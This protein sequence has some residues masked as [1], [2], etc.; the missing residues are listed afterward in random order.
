MATDRNG[1]ESPWQ[2]L[3]GPNLGYVQE[4]YERYLADPDSIDPELKQLFDQ[5]G[6]PPSASGTAA[7]NIES[8]VDLEKIVAAV[9]F[10]DNIRAYGHLAAD[11]YPVNGHD[12][13][14]RMLEPSNYGLTE[15]DLRA[16]PARLVWKGAPADVRD[17][18]EA[19]RRLKEIYTQTIAYDFSHVHDAE[20]IRW[21]YEMAESGA[22]KPAMTAEK[23]KALLKELTDVEGFETFLHRT[24]VGQKRFSIEGVDVLVPMLNE[25]I[26][27]GVH[28]GAKNVIIGMA[29][30]GR[31]NVLAHVL[32]KPLELIIAEFA[33][34]PQKSHPASDAAAY[35]NEGW[36]G[37]VKYHLGGKY[38]IKE[39][40]AVVA[41]LTLANNPSHLEVVDPVVEG[42]TRAAQDDRS[43]RGYPEQDQNKAFAI[44]VHGDA[45]FPGEGVVAETLNLSR[46]RGYQTGGTIHIIANNLIG[47][48]TE[49]DDGRST[50]Y[51]SDLAKGFEIPV[52][53]VNADDPEAC[54]AAMHF[55]YEYRKRF[56]KDFL[57]DLIG[58][59]RLGHNEMDDPAVTQP[60]LYE[61]ISNHKRV[62]V[63]YAEKL[64]SEGVVTAEE[65][66]RL[67]KEVQNKLQ[68]I[69][70]EIRA[71]N[72]GKIEEKDLP[73]AVRGKWPDVDTS[74]P[75][76]NLKAIN[77]DLLKW[78]DGFHVYRKLEKIL[79]RRANAL[80]EGGKVDWGHAEALA[81]ATILQ[82]G[83]PI[84][85]TGQDAER[86][87]FAHR[88]LVL[89]DEA[90]G[91][92][93]SPLHGL[94]Q[95]NASFAIHNSPLTETAVLG[96]EYG[97][98]VF[99]PE[100][101]VLWEAQ[102][103]D[104]ANVAQPIFDQFISAGR[105]KW[106]QKSG[107]VMLLPH[108]YE[109][110]GAEHSSARLERYL[111]LAAENNW[112]VANLTSSAQYF[113]ILRR[114]AAMLGTDRVRP[115]VLMTPKSLLRHQ[116]VAS[117]AEAFTN[118]RFHLVLE[119]PGLGTKPESVERLV[120]ASGK[121]AIDLAAA[122]EA[123]PENEALN[124]IHIVRV[125]QLYPFPEEEIRAVLGRFP[126]LKEI[127]WVQEEPK[128]MGAWT[129]M[130]PRLRA[131]APEGVPVRYIGR[132]DRSSPAVGEPDVH[133][134]EQERIIKEALRSMSRV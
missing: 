94:P 10:A 32:K 133:K 48:T 46:L 52:I 17:G 115:L 51:S 38:A 95:A 6:A 127:V 131:L 121:I 53:H 33:H 88:H 63:L 5:W 113:H 92:T 134:L 71:N 34:A 57:I 107:L 126:N 83:T 122:I 61:R 128:N 119:Q 132:P 1:H 22:F 44:L 64:E 70:D 35:I 89:H 84:R 8:G 41:R 68:A 66:D 67:E 31:L 25:I 20:E 105:A 43:R 106:G 15:A 21:L 37:D 62:R 86:G 100:T 109:G 111:Q 112:T 47:F 45:A 120:L 96:F 91:E 36:T 81:F 73:Q 50:R 14:T 110:Q 77:A 101:L 12:A 56:K 78:P 90:T 49:S 60:K 130:E 108:G 11:L 74:V 123:E 39:G 125:E 28:D 55:A 85:L 97:Y 103:G 80:D 98:N 124:T 4:Q 102:Y 7:P 24:F 65:V 104:F 40:E 54:L 42:Y 82:D 114:Q 93:Y 59:R 23:R 116:A 18:W 9:K 87:T 19:I 118:D 27:E 16:I 29:H 30:R 117:P 2:Q 76:D 72:N 58:Y 99:A 129:F 3:Y 69:Y 75:L 13:D 79:M 26:R